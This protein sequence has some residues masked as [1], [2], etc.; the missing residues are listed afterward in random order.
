MSQ[1]DWTS[2]GRDWPNRAASRFVDSGGLHWHVQE[3]GGGEERDGGK[4]RGARPRLLLAHGT[5]GATHSWRQL[6]PLL[7]QHFSVLAPD[8]PGHG[9]TRPA[10]T[11][12]GFAK[13]AERRLSLPGMAESLGDLLKTTAFDPEIV[14]GH[15]A[16]AAVLIRMTLDR[17]I[18]PRL[19]VSL[20]GAL[21][22][23]RGLASQVFSPLAKLLVLNPFVPRLAAWHASGGNVVARLIRDT[24]SKI[25]DEGLALYGRLIGNPGH[26][27]AALAMMANWDLDEFERDIRRLDVPLLLVAGGADRAIPADEAFRVRDR[28][29]GARVSVLRSLGHLAHEEAPDTVATLIV[30]AAAAEGIGKVTAT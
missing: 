12:G 23:F 26:V 10:A 2:D 22:P 21:L 17:V 29:P 24:G 16:G 27:G 1:L 11:A 19:I 5:A 14:V 15:S 8:L 28:V 4:E 6:L 13:I 9:F 20:N 3:L 7:G 25:D 18:R 30:E